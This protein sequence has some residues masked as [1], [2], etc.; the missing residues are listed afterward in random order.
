M[1]VT[2][3]TRLWYS[4]RIMW[5]GG[6][7]LFLFQGWCKTRLPE[8]PTITRDLRATACYELSLSWALSLSRLNF[9]QVAP[10]HIKLFFPH[11]APLSF[12]L[13]APQAP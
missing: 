7:G 3:L 1:L 4:H 11:L 5:G 2:A 12:P 9:T 6:K 8:V 10:M 13:R